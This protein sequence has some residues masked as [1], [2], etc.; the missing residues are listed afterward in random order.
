MTLELGGKSAM[1]VFDDADVENAVKG[2]MLANFL[3]QGQV[4][5]I[6]LKLLPI[7]LLY[8]STSNGVNSGNAVH[9]KIIF[10]VTFIS[11]KLLEE[12]LLQGRELFIILFENN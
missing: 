11:H 5:K 3:N 8:M 1:I 9:N 6:V 10:S 12:Y 2:A 7:N 4:R